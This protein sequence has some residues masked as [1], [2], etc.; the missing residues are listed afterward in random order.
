MFIA[1]ACRRARSPLVLFTLVGV[2]LLAAM[3]V[4]AGACCPTGWST[5]GLPTPRFGHGVAF[6]SDRD[7]LVVFGGRQS[8]TSPLLGDTW[9]FDGTRWRQTA[10]GGPAP[11]EQFAMVYHAGIDKVVLVGGLTA[12]GERSDVWT[13]DAA[14]WTQLADGPFPPRRGHAAAYDSVRDRMVMHG[15][16]Q[17][18]NITWMFDGTSW[19][20]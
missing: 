8:S 10:I 4:R 14:G 1:H 2:S 9:E 12:D 3:P 18:D 6:D 16:S 19:S 5:P 20:S 17:L 7:V 15:G 13:Y 11:R